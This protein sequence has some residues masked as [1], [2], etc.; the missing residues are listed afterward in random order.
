[1]SDDPTPQQSDIEQPDVE[2][3]VRFEIRNQV[4]WI[5]IDNPTKGNA[6]SPDMRDRMASL[7]NGC[8][9]RFEARAIVIT[10]V[11]RKLFCPGADISV[12]REFAPRPD[13]A[14]PLAVG[15]SRRMMLE[16]QLKL[17]PAILDSELP[18]IAAV[19]G[20]AAGVGAHLALCCDLVIMADNAKFIEVFARRGLVP[21]GLG[22]WILPRL[23]GLQKAK[24]LMFFAEDISAEEALRIGLCN[25]VVPGDDLIEA[26]TEWAERLASGPTRSFMLT[27]WL[28][29]RSLDV[30]R[31]TLEDNEAWAV[32]LN[33][34]TVDSAEGLASFRE[35][36]DPVW[37]GF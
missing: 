23:V 37:R 34:G 27:K 9:G 24:E 30:D 12:G 15:E 8:N 17:M 25:R 4:A 21:D 32:E 16:G 13:D 33:N 36:R 20:T 5:T 22:A 11:G 35:R 3:Q 14:P 6:I 18:V 26:A 7:I 10:A 31:R 2:E 1:M 28:V 19:N 29:N